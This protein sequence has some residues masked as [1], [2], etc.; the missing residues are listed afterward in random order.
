MIKLW[1]SYLFGLK[2]L[3]EA[4]KVKGEDVQRVDMLQLRLKE[5]IEK[6]GYGY[7][8]DLQ[9][10]RI[11]IL[12]ELNDITRSMYDISFDEYCQACQPAISA[13]VTLREELAVVEDVEEPGSSVTIQEELAVVEDVEV[14][15]SSEELLLHRIQ[16][17]GNFLLAL[18]DYLVEI[19]KNAQKTKEIFAGDLTGVSQ[20]QCENIFS[21]FS[22][23]DC[24]NF[25]EYHPA[26]YKTKVRLQHLN[27]QIKMLIDMC[28]ICGGIDLP[29]RSTGKK[30]QSL[31][32]LLDLLM[33]DAKSI[34]TLIKSIEAKI[35]I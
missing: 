16:Q 33:Y 21:S 19:Q 7:S 20:K 32:A 15:G 18:T 14:P 12:D 17:S 22:L 13:T 23:F 8:K 28:E 2:S 11:E 30:V 26:L 6:S 10:D 35:V 9:A 25:P 27:E 3:K 1:K 29:S 34:H 5:N 24:S 4:I 31:I